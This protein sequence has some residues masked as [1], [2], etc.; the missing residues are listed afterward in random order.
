MKTL[1]TCENTTNLDKCVICKEYTP[2]VENTDVTYRSY[3]IE[4]AGQLCKE[5]YTKVYVPKTNNQ[6]LFG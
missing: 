6:L 4:G 5:C 2:Y 3:Y 1:I